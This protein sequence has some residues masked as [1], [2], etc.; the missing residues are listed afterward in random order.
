MFQAGSVKARAAAAATFTRLD[1]YSKD[2]TKALATLQ[3]KVAALR[4]IWPSPTSTPRSRPI[5]P[6]PSPPIRRDIALLQG[7]TFPAA[8]AA[9][10]ADKDQGGRSVSKAPFPMKS[11]AIFSMGAAF[12][13]GILVS[14]FKRE[15]SAEEMFEAEKVR[16]YVGVGAEGSASH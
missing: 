8:L 2:T 1:G 9:A 7:G 12:L 15:K 4:R 5:R 3:T 14:L 10:K 13:V 16:T 6:R 11:P